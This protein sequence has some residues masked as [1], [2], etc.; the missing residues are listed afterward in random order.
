M[1]EAVLGLS[2][3]HCPGKVVINNG[4]FPGAAPGPEAEQEKN[5]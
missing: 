1:V 3:V 4:K 2:T 5:E